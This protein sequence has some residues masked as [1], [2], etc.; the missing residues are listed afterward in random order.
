MRL[1]DGF[2]PAPGS[3]FVFMT[4]SLFSS[5]TGTFDELELI[6]PPGVEFD[7]QLIY[8][9]TA[10]TFEVLMAEL[11][12]DFDDDLDIDAD[13]IDQLTTAIRSMSS[14]A[15]FDLNGDGILNEMD[16]T[17]M[18]EDVLGTFFGDANLDRVV[19]GQD[20]LEWNSAKFTDG[21]GWATGDFN[22]DG[23]SDGQDFLQWNANKFA[24]V[25]ANGATVPEPTALWLMWGVLITCSSLLIRS[26]R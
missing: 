15:R 16:L 8:A 23:A 17:S 12:A 20:F 26:H 2:L 10:V 14:D 18:I 6:A 7:G 25:A 19:D 13:D 9:S 24:S 22:G 4:G 21:T 11:I 3:D 5:I 1:A